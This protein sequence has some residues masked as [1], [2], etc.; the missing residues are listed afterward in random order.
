MYTFEIV[1]RALFLLKNQFFWN[2]ISSGL[3]SNN[4]YVSPDIKKVLVKSFTIAVSS[5][6]GP[7]EKRRENLNQVRFR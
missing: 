2:I 5:F 7:E 3:G 4:R 1:F 6:E